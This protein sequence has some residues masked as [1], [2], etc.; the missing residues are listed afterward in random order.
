MST[1]VGSVRWA[2]VVMSAW[3]WTV[4][5]AA[6]QTTI[7]RVSTDNLGAQAT[8]G[9]STTPSVS[10]DGRYVAFASTATNLVPGDTNQLSDIF[11]KDRQTGAIERV[12]VR[13][14]GTQAG[15]GGSYAP[16][17]SA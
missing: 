13:T 1:R 12:S 5:L 6:A 15:D 16:S 11:V 2:G 4:G 14:D 8:G 9:D 3:A 17:I 10:A 7:A